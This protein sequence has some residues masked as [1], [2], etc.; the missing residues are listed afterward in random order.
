MARTQLFRTSPVLVNSAPAVI[1]LKDLAGV[2]P[3]TLFVENM[4]VASSGRTKFGSKNANLRF[5]AVDA[6]SHGNNYSV[7]FH[8]AANQAFSIEVD[9]YDI[10]VNLACDGSG[11]P[12][13]LATEVMDLMNEDA[14]VSAIMRVVLAGFPTSTGGSDGGATLEVQPGTDVTVDLADGALAVATG[15]ATVEISPTGA[16]EGFPGP[17]VTHAAAVTAL[18]TVAP[19][20]MKSYTF[21]EPIRGLRL[22]V[23]SGGV[24]HVI[25]SGQASQA[26]V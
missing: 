11:T 8:A 3:F 2:A 16:Q 6:G 4:D 5:I 20:T 19:N 13:Q 17:W 14:Y 12:Y 24:T 25:A 21:T 10:T 15:A 7:I 26:L 23:T 22:G 9:A 18:S 1:A